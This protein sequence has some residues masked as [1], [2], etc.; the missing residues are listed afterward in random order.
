MSSLRSDVRFS[1][2]VLAT[3][4]G[5]AATA[6]LVL[7]LGIG[8]NAAV[9]SVVNAL[10][11]RPLAGVREPE[12]VVG[13]YARH[14]RQA[15]TYRG[16]SYPNYVDV[17]EGIRSFE[18]V[19]AFTFVLAGVAES[20]VTRRSLVMMVSA[21]YFDVLGARPMLGRAFTPE[22]ERPGS[23]AQVAVASHAYW[24]GHGADAA[25]VGRAVSINGR[26]FTVVGIA[27]P[28]F[29]GTSPALAAE[30]WLPLS[31]TKLVESDFLR[32]IAGGDLTS[33]DTHRF[34][35][36]GRLKPGT[37]QE[38]AN[39]ELGAVAVTLARAHPEANRDYTVIAHALQ[40]RGFAATPGDDVSLIS[41]STVLLGMSAVV[42]LVA[43]LNLANM[44]LARGR[45]RRKEIAIRLSM[46][47]SRV[48]VVR[49]LLVEGFLLSLGGGVAGLTLGH[50]AMVTLV[51][52]IAPLLP[53]P[54]DVPMILDWRATAATLAWA[55]LATIV[56]A[57]GPALK[58]TRPGVIDELKEQAGEDRSRRAWLFG[59]RNLIL[60][61]QIALS[62]A[63]LVT[64][65]LFVRGA[66]KA[67]D[68]TPGFPLER[69]MV[70]EVDPGLAGYSLEEGAD[71]HRRAVARLRDLPGVEAAS[72]ASMVPFGRG[73]DLVLVERVAAAPADGKPS[74]APRPVAA[75]HTSI[76]GDYFR[77]LG[78]RV[79]RGRD[80]GAAEAEGRDARRVAIIDEPAARLLFPS[81][82][83]PVG[84][85]VKVGGGDGGPP[86][87]VCEVVGLVAG[88]RSSLSDRTPTPHLYVPFSSRIRT[89]MYYHVRPAPGVSGDG[90][91]AGTL[92]GELASLDPRLP[93][94]S[95]STLEAFTKRS[96]FLWLFRAGA[97]V[98]TAFGL[99]GLVL[100][101]VGIWG[102]NAYMVL[103]RAREIG[104]RMALGATPAGVVWLVVRD[105]TLVTAAGVLAG[106]AFA[107][108]IA[109][110][111]GSMLYEVTAADPVALVAAPALLAA[112][113]LAASYLPARKAARV[114][115]T[116]ALRRE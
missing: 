19:S 15:D 56:F 94:L 85:S 80:F 108:A 37:A 87:E 100:A 93:L 97:R 33:R 59:A 34:L 60:G 20:G 71:A 88:V 43:C 18:G 77:S 23:A 25:L 47:A 84:Q 49:Q 90:P 68:A 114:A 115:V 69:G 14:V 38:I 65:A 35:L 54:F 104:I 1:L 30:F 50:W 6:V 4:P 52:S 41:M 28:G 44:L 73:N 61:G 17:R 92:R 27:P 13:L 9:F 107:V 112:C 74:T 82:E 66:L 103:R 2:R 76:G 70:V 48:A 98:F 29:A 111:L 75:A 42:L 110:L 40:R 96:P 36:F 39:R 101:L 102:V 45:S 16:F 78:I 26:L 109:T 12:R 11:L 8:A 24:Q 89:A 10:L 22:E 62:L 72:M 7:A 95:I 53:M 57:L 83:S 99:A 106:T 51:R 64:G 32:D 79:L 55:T 91:L 5:F 31:A 113:A 81:G 86:P 21:N 63:L 105:T 46:G 3:Q 58:A 67:A 116:A